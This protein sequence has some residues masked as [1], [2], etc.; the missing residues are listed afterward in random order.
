MPSKFSIRFRLTG[1]YSLSLAVVLGLLAVGS[2]FAMRASL[3][4]TV[5]G[6]LRYRLLGVEQFISAQSSATPDDLSEELAEAGSLDVLFRIFDETGKLTFESA[7]LTSHGVDRTPP[8]IRGEGI[9]YREFSKSWPL[10]LAAQR[11]QFRGHPI[12]IE[13]AQ[14]LRFHQ[15][16][17]HE[18]ARSLLISIPLLV[19]LAT[20]VGYWLAGRALAPVNQIVHDARTIDASRLSKRLSVSPAH[21]ELRLLSE[22][23]N[24]MLDRIEGSMTRIK[25]F[26]ADASHELRAPLTLIQTAAEFTLR[27]ERSHAENVEAMEKVLRE[28]K[29]TSQLIDSL[30][31]LA[32][33]DSEEEVHSTG[34][35]RI[36]SVLHDVIERAAPLASG[37]SI[38]ISAEIDAASVE[39]AGEEALVSRLLFILIDNAIKYTPEGGSI[40]V[41]LLSEEGSA[42]IGV[43]D[44]GIG[45]AEEDLPRV[46]DRFWRA[47]K[48]RSRSMGGAGLGLSIAKWI[49]EKSG[50]TIHVESE[51]GN[52]STFEV[53]L[54][55][56]TSSLVQPATERS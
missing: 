19:V 46:F 34:T 28:S 37:K 31:L 53:R 18:F 10:R 3:Y 2:Y 47:D 43:Q 4:R 14:P 6:E 40:K 12:I 11:V 38:K 24:S 21:D 55:K 29:R 27:R 7:P 26:T 52:G 44:T 36:N 45:I 17:L 8:S 13:V 23:L 39:V 48:V 1:W 42:L 25:Q 33:A 5:D 30:L 15:T 9:T 32:R 56:L 51:L 22:T 49:V 16:S 35:V 50:G 41:S 54:P 20:L